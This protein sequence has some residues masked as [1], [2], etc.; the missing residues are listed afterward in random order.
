M[1]KSS[2]VIVVSVLALCACLFHACSSDELDEPQ[3]T[4]KAQLLLAKSREFAKKYGVDVKLN[5]AN[6]EEIAQ[7][8]TVEELETDFQMFAALKGEMFTAVDSVARVRRGMKLRASTKLVEENKQQGKSGFHETSVS[9][10]KNIMVK[11]NKYLPNG[12]METVQEMRTIKMSGTVR[13]TW[14]KP[15]EGSFS[16]SASADLTEGYKGS[17]N[18]VGSCS[19]SSEGYISFSVGS[20]MELNNGYYSVGSHV[21]ASY[22]E[23]DGAYRLSV[24]VL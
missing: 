2:L 7:T 14:K 10:E 21:D 11:V 18:L 9:L 12:R 4:D 22:N 5:E 24:S 1:K 15:A 23:R 3:P 13:L 17:C 16:A 20:N 8:K 6:L 19:S